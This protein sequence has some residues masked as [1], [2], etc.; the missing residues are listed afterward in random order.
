M[1]SS[2]CIIFVIFSFLNVRVY[3]QDN[4]LTMGYRTNEKLPFIAED[5]DSSGIFKELYEEAANRL[6]FRLEI[7]RLP[8][9]RIILGL[10]EGSIDF[11]PLY[12]YSNERSAYVYFAPNGL[13][14]SYSVLSKDD[15]PNIKTGTDLYGYVGL[16]SLGSPTYLTGFDTS[17]IDESWI[18]EMDIA[19]AVD[20]ILMGRG[21][22]YIYES[23]PLIF[24][25]QKH[26]VTGVR[27]QPIVVNV[28]STAYIGLSKKSP[29]YQEEVNTDF[30]PL[31][32]VS[33]ENSP[34][35]LVPG[36]IF[37]R[38]LQV[39]EEM[40]REGFTDSLSLRYLTD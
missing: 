27:L 2:V 6:G 10:D 19:K 9:N 17:R 38:L 37:Y 11:Y 12:T 28:E 8:K 20:M 35:R 32:L 14:V 21:D 34:V 36:S 22:F 30:D 15:F 3:A 18:T 26:E 4:V 1:R 7:V 25:I 23:E 33:P 13:E 40:D 16:V 29:Y 31:K 39:L 24:Y 5:P